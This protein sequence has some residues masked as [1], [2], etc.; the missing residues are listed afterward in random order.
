MS[1]KPT[2]DKGRR[3]RE[4]LVSSGRAVFARVGYVDARMSDVATEAD[5]S[6]GGLYRY[7]KNKEDLFAQVIADLHEKLYEASASHHQDFATNPYRTLLE[8][9]RGYLTLY[10]ENREVMRAFIQAAHVEER[11][12]DIWWDMRVRHIDRFVK[13]LAAVHGI[14]EIDG[15]DARVATE[16]MACMV[17]QSAYVWYAQERRHKTDVDV[18]S[19]A[20]IVARAWYQTFFAGSEPRTDTPADRA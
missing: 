20:R 10:K 19:A 8:S 9:N 1:A 2:T 5:I 14:S 16:A 4:H 17:E 15:A 18:D 13:A 7:F 6:M 12:Q 11:F 3:T